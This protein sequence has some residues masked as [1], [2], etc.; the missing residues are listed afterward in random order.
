MG[1]HCEY[2]VKVEYDFIHDGLAL[3]YTAYWKDRHE[4]VYVEHEDGTCFGRYL[5]FTQL[6]GYLVTFPGEKL[7]GY[8][9]NGIQEEYEE[10]DQY[11]KCNLH[12]I[13]ENKEKDIKEIVEEHPEYK[14]FFKSFNGE[15]NQLLAAVRNWKKDSSVEFLMK[16]GFTELASSKW[17]KTLSIANKRKLVEILKK[18]VMTETIT[19]DISPIVARILIAENCSLEDAL[20]AAYTYNGS[21]QK[22]LYLKDTDEGFKM[23]YKE[24]R[25]LIKPLKKHDKYWFYP[26]KEKL[27]IMVEKANSMIANIEKA[28]LLKKEKDFLKATRKYKKFSK[29][30]FYG[31]IIYVPTDV[32]DVKEQADEL[33]QC[34]ITSD[35]IS[36]VIRKDSL[37]VFV[38][39]GDKRIATY[40][41]DPRCNYKI[42]QFYA[43]EKDRDHCKPTTQ[44]DN[45]VRSWLS[46]MVQQLS[47]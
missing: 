4:T 25:A 29:K 31:L 27:P 9:G 22:Y 7:S 32:L 18:T 12:A 36:K 40:E 33:N 23:D 2:K 8:Y 17:I 6:A 37:L 44:V 15:L 30:D 43:N 21:Y 38:K 10:F 26:N 14:Y 11:N 1:H 3:V 47:C 34:L 41:L 35:Y 13:W 16:N 5:Y 46:S 24:Y 20:I 45:I 19:T 42:I 39:K 28:K